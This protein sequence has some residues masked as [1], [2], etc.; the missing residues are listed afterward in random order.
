ML[1]GFTS[2][3]SDLAIAHKFAE[4]TYGNAKEMDHIFKAILII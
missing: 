1:I 4:I 2:T 3:S